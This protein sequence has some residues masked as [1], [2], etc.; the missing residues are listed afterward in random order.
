MTRVTTSIESVFD[1]LC[2]C[3]KKKPKYTMVCKE[4]DDE[5]HFKMLTEKLLHNKK[6]SSTRLNSRR[7][8]TTT[9]QRNKINDITKLIVS[10]NDFVQEKNA[11]PSDFYEKLTHLGEGSFGEVYKVR[12]KLTGS[13]RAMKIISQSADF[14]FDE[15]EKE[16]YMLKS[17]SHPNIIKIFEVF[18]YNQ[19]IYLVEEYVKGGDL[20]S[21]I[22]KMNNLSEKITLIIMK[23]IFSAVY[24]LHHNG[25][26]H[27]DLKLENIMVESLLK[28]RAT[29]VL[30]DDKSAYDFDIKLIDFGCSA[31]FFKEQPLTKL[32]GTIYYLAPEVILG[33][34][35]N[36][37]DIWS[38]G[39][40]MYVLLCGKF[41]FNGNNTEEILEKIKNCDYSLAEREFNYIS[42]ETKDLL[43]KCLEVDPYKRI[44]A[45]KALE[46]D[47]FK[48]LDYKDNEKYDQLFNKN[49][50]R[51][52]PVIENLTHLKRRLTFQK[53]IIKFITFNLVSPEEITNIR[54]LYKLMDKNDDGYL[55]IDE[56]YEGFALSGKIINESEFNKIVEALDP[57]N[58]GIIEYED[59]IS[60]CVSKEK[61]LEEHNLQNAFNI[62]DIDSSGEI[63]VDEIKQAFNLNGKFL[64]EEVSEEIMKELDMNN[65]REIT[66][67]EFKKLV[68][69]AYSD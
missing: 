65:Q 33:A 53:A 64:D 11:N 7:I 46:H 37:C 3:C 24:Y 28:K 6:P 18:Q 63:S 39:V 68:E 50:Q 60:A 36:K 8:K 31:M 21:K 22:L 48:L 52:D 62:I 47:C 15:F 56:L 5:E 17:V 16:A 12:N 49:N 9:I 59:F 2:C 26:I 69:K 1:Y 41:P 30:A 44:N 32:I 29:L 55:T 34:Y 42:K 35:N 25:M 45:K 23:Q 51:Y 14:E 38:C 10:E 27:G 61:I 20:F 58:T 66:F 13:V 4:G 43:K 57:H 40:I 19:A 67:D 54:N